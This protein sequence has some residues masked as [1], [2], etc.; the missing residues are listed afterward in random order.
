MIVS[1]A[2]C[3]IALVGVVLL[4]RHRLPSLGLPVAYLLLMLVIHLPG[5]VAHAVHGERMLFTEYTEIGIRLT[6]IGAL[7]FVV[8]VWLARLKGE[9]RVKV[10]LWPGTNFLLFCVVG[11]WIVTF[12]LYPFLMHIPTVCSMV[13]NGCRLWIIGIMLALP[14]HLFQRNMPAVG[15]WLAAMMVFSVWM[16]VFGGFLTHSVR[17]NVLC[18]SPLFVLTNRVWKV[19]AVI[20]I[21]IYLGISFFVSY[22]IIRDEIRDKV[23]GRKSLEERWNVS[24]RIIREFQWIDFQNPKHLNALDQRLNQNYFVGLSAVRLQRGVVSYRQGQTLVDG[25]LMLIPRA[26]WPNKPL[27]GGSPKIVAEMTGLLLEKNTSWGV[28]NVME[29]YINFGMPSLVVGFLAMGFVLG[30]LDYWGALA[31]QQGNFLRLISTALPAFALVQF[32]GSF[33]EQVGGAAGGALA[34]YFWCS[35]WRFLEEKAGRRV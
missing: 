23:W 28:G 26:I 31:F 32:E 8:G 3:V 20:L 21:S 12:V 33:V 24:S 25:A 16:L 18:L 14:V 11:G 27:R 6:S 30:K 2:L 10:A 19:W 7:C 1:I 22:F 29:F 17:A 13:D 4:V 15:F 35:L 5:A 34:A 9:P